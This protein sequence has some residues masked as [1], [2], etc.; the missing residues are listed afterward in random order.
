MLDP[1]TYGEGFR[2]YG[3]TRPVKACP[4]YPWR[5]AQWPA[6]PDRSGS[7]PPR[8]ACGRASPQ[9][10]PGLLGSLSPDG[11]SVP[12][13]QLQNAVPQS[14]SPFR[15][16]GRS[17]HEAW[18]AKAISSGAPAAASCSSTYRHR[19]SRIPVFSLPSESPCTSFTELHVGIGKKGPLSGGTVPHPPGAGPRHGPVP[20]K[21]GAQPARAS[22]NA[23]NKPAGPL[24][25]HRQDGLR[26]GWEEDTA[27]PS[28]GPPCPPDRCKASSSSPRMDTSSARENETLSGAGRQPTVEKS[29]RSPIVSRDIFRIAPPP[30]AYRRQY[31]PTAGLLPEFSAY[32]LSFNLPDSTREATAPRAAA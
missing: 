31:I 21:R 17:P 1:H 23:A 30:G 5:C 19:G 18:P 7:P 11:K 25:H 29:A 13:P 14:L 27:P 2:L 3:E 28:R 24:H 8:K 6:P 26:A 9:A 15:A 12:L 32:C 16:G 10:A 20:A 4:R 22:T